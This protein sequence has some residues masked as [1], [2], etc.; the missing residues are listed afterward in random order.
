MQCLSEGLCSMYRGN[1][2]FIY[3]LHRGYIRF[4]GA[5]KG[6]FDMAAS[7]KGESLVKIR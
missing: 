1:R 4:I 3:G 5:M 2:E 6:Y 7:Q